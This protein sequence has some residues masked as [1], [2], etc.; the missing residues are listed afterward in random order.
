MET[1]MNYIFALTLHLKVS[2][3]HAEKRRKELNH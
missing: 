1:F 3:R 2:K